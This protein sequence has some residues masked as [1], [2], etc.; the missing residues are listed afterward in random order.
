[1][2]GKIWLESKLTEGSTF[3]FS[4]PYIPDM[5][6][7][8]E[9]QLV[10]GHKVYNWASKTILVA[11]DEPLNFRFFEEILEDTD[12]N[13]I[14]VKNGREAVETCSKNDAIDL[15]LMDIKMLNEWIMMP[16]G[17]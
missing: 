3:Y 10:P 14:W 9:P 7:N 12:V 17:Q 4:L 13:I 11:E 16:P 2:G 15:I 5:P 1:M 8:S 6:I